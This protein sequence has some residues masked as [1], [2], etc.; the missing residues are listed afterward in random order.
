M[1]FLIALGH[2]GGLDYWPVCHRSWHEYA[3]RHGYDV[4]VE[5]FAPQREGRGHPS[6]QKLPLLMRLISEARYDWILW[7]DADTVVTEHRVDLFA[8][9]IL[10]K[11]H[12]PDEPW[13]L[14]SKDWNDYSP[15]SAGVM[16]VRSCDE[17]L[18]FFTETSALTE[19]K[20]A[21]CWDQDAMHE[22]C[23]RRPDLAR[24]LKI[25]PRRILQSVPND[26]IRPN[27]PWQEGDF[28]CHATG[29]E[30]KAKRAILERYA[31]RAIR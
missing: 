2:D 13:M 3:N 26:A 21:G 28:S 22:L 20:N 15:W 7:A 31:A 29:I 8:T 14:V 25:L 17:A 5:M 11:A 18:R 19:Y 12:L 10:D 1:K 9:F 4:H 30:Q 6:W 16:L 27:E 24:G 23:N